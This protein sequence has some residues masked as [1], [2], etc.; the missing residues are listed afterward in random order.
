M[1]GSLT[2]G[3]VTAFFDEISEERL[4]TKRAIQ[5]NTGTNNIRKGEAVVSDFFMLCV[6]VVWFD[7]TN[8]GPGAGLVKSFRLSACAARRTRVL[9]YFTAFA[10]SQMI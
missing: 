6:Q 10:G 7:D 3:P 9:G 4:K 1:L 8:K 5:K 2:A